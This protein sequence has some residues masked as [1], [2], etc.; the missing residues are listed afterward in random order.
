MRRVM[1]TD[2]MHI[3]ERIREMGEKEVVER[4]NEFL[5]VNSAHTLKNTC[6]LSCCYV[7]GAYNDN[8]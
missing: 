5:Q 1:V 7:D 3:Y 2:N 4:E 8:N 6:S